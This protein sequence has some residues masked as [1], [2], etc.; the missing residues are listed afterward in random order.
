MTR[1]SGL[2][3]LVQGVA[4][5]AAL[6]RDADTRIAAGDSRS[7]GQIMADT[8]VERVTGQTTAEA[9]PIEVNLILPATTLFARPGEPGRDEPA[10]IPGHGPVPAAWAD[11]K[12]TRL[13]SSHT[14]LSRMPSSA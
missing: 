9:V 1:L 12:S 8:L 14:V 11:R 6:H 2:L 7:R 5:F 3:P 10:V 4:T 13:N